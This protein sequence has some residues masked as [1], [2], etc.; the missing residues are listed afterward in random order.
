MTTIERPISGP[1]ANWDEPLDEQKVYFPVESYPDRKDATKELRD[2]IEETSGGEPITPG[3]AKKGMSTFCFEHEYCDVA[4][5]DHWTPVECWIYSPREKRIRPN[6]GPPVIR[7]C[8]KCRLLVV[9]SFR[10]LKAYL[11]GTWNGKSGKVDHCPGSKQVT[12]DPK[13]TSR[14]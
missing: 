6:P 14:V 7:R 8:S 4:E 5:K 11:H 2:L 1:Y 9:T 10:S 12:L 13:T 3:P